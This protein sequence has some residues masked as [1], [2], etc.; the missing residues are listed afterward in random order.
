LGLDLRRRA[1]T[2]FFPVRK[3]FWREWFVNKRIEIRRS[4]LA[5][6]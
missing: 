2:T 1:L 3:M 5:A 6:P 4:L